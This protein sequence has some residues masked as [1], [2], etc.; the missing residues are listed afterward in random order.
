VEVG[1][2]C[3]DHGGIRAARRQSRS[4]GAGWDGGRGGEGRNAARGGKRRAKTEFRL[5]LLFEC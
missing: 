5:F 4:R 2:G 1:E 3:D